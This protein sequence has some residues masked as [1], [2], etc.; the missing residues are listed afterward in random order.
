[1]ELEV[2]AVGGMESCFVSLPLFLIQTLEKTRGGFLPPVLALELRSRSGGGCWN[3]AWSGSASRSA[4][5]EVTPPNIQSSILLSIATLI[6]F[7]LQSSSPFQV[8]QLLAEC[9]SLQDHAKVQVKAIANL[10]KAEFVNIEPSSEDDW[11][12]LELNSDVKVK[13]LT[14]C[15]AEQ[16]EEEEEEKRKKYLFSPCRFR[17]RVVAALAP[18]PPMGRLR[19]VAALARGQFFSRAKRQNVSPRG[20]KD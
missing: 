1:M 16:E 15:N 2:R 20:E 3:L 12:I 11:E 18:S 4:A 19:A 17:S 14:P 10:P 6:E 7:S 13:Q 5:I 8:D 9:I